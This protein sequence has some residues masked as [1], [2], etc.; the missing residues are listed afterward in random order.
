[1]AKR[2]EYL[3]EAER[4][5]VRLLITYAEEHD[6]VP[7]FSVLKSALTKS[8]NKIHSEVHDDLCRKLKIKMTPTKT[9]WDAISSPMYKDAYKE[10]M[11]EAKEKKGVYGIRL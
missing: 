7:D 5:I 9:Y 1:M 8:Y 2:K 3:E 6:Q 4:A 10:L 11:I